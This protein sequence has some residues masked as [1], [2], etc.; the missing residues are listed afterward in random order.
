MLH[1]KGNHTPQSMEMQHSGRHHQDLTG[2]LQSDCTMQSPSSS[3]SGPRKATGMHIL[4]GLSVSS[5]LLKSYNVLHLAYP[6]RST[7]LVILSENRSHPSSQIGARPQRSMRKFWAPSIEGSHESWLEWAIL[8][9]PTSTL[10][11][12]SLLVH[13]T[14]TSAVFSY[15]TLIWSALLWQLYCCLWML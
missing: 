14:Y 6:G 2:S 15:S 3:Y 12:C 13:Y 4:M 10:A 11:K 9:P 8:V 5:H 1:P 7:G